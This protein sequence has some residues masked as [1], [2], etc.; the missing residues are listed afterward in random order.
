MKKAK[1][2]HEGS[3][4]HIGLV[5]LLRVPAWVHDGG[6]GSTPLHR[7][8]HGLRSQPLDVVRYIQGVCQLF[9]SLRGGLRGGA[10]S[11]RALT[12]CWVITQLNPGIK[13]PKETQTR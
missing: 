7:F 3:S 12:V 9:W 6:V 11:T 4:E 10:E 13:V 8:F 5:L 2:L 1:N